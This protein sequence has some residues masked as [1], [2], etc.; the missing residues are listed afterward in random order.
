MI[1]KSVCALVILMV[2]LPL[3]AATA[4]EG[5]LSRDAEKLHGTALR[6]AKAREIKDQQM[7]LLVRAWEE[8]ET[9]ELGRVI[10]MLREA[11]DPPRSLPDVIALLVKEYLQRQF[12][13]EPFQ[14]IENLAV[15]IADES[16]EM[17]EALLVEA[18]GL[19]DLRF[20]RHLALREARAKE[21]AL[22]RRAALCLGDLVNYGADD[23]NVSGTLIALLD[24]LEPSVR[25]VAARRA[26][27]ARLD[28]V[29]NWAIQNLDDAKKE[30]VTLRG[31][32]E[33]VGPGEEA[34]RGL[35]R[36]TRL[37]EE[38]LHRQYL[39]M[40]LTEKSTTCELFR[41]WWRNHG[42]RFPAPGFRE[43]DFRRE[44]STKQTIVV[45]AGGEACAFQFWSG[46]DRTKIRFVADELELHAKSLL[47]FEVNF[48][49][50]YMA[51]GMRSDD[52]EGYRRNLVVGE[53][54]ILAR[55]AIGCYVLVFQRMS[56]DRIG[57]HLQFHDLE[58]L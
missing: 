11:E 6:A 45:K 12:G 31:E 57:V 18:M 55:K 13:D 46:L 54:Y 22:R 16:P 9:A 35:S 51:Q 17:R 30:A 44:P 37:K 32:E 25:A 50:R 47:D 5:E 21:P 53:K 23:G 43:A 33:T 24:D 14:E 27:E 41:G 15:L 39:S 10:A 4:Q 40:S 58:S 2:V 28:V 34:L 29:F 49:V 36:L 1:P 19:A 7:R 20:A 26:F 3:S 42:E 56:G 52:G 38:L 48:H 8:V